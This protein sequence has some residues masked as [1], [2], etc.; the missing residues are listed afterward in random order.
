MY[1]KTYHGDEV[2]NITV[3]GDEG[4]VVAGSDEV[5]AR[6]GREAEGGGGWELSE[7]SIMYA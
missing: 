1:S 6:D 2:T 7:V 4:V 5:R 3:L